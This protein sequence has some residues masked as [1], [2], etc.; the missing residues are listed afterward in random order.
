MVVVR[1]TVL[2]CSVLYCKH[3][4][5]E[6]FFIKFSFS[7]SKL[8]INLK[9]LSKKFR[10]QNLLDFLCKCWL[11][12]LLQIRLESSQVDLKSVLDLI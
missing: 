8:E 1:E 11:T 6:F 2:Y 9:G 5:N 4:Q 10:L 7:V 12:F 3:T